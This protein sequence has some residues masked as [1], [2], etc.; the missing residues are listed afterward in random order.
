MAFDES[1]AIWVAGG[2]G[3]ARF[4]DTRW[5]TPAYP[6]DVA[7]GRLASYT[8]GGID[9]S[10]EGWASN[11]V[12][13]RGAAGTFLRLERNAQNETGISTPFTWGLEG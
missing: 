5:E 3:A 4:A 1:G 6:R 12:E 11:G 13:I 8:E 9:W 2:T 10:S 7:G